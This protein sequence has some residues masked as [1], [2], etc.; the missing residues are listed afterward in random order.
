MTMR[1]LVARDFYTEL[2]VKQEENNIALSLSVL[3]Y[4]S[5]KVSLVLLLSMMIIHVVAVQWIRLNPYRSCVP[6]C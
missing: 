2:I 3:E 5:F 4:R 1:H 6:D